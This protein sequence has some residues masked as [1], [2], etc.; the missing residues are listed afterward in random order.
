M[1]KTLSSSSL[2]LKYES[3]VW[4][5]G[6]KG[7]QNAEHHESWQNSSALQPTELNALPNCFDLEDALKINAVLHEIIF[8]D[9]PSHLYCI[10]HEMLLWF[11]CTVIP[12]LQ[13]EP[14][15]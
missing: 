13:R 12:V 10:C 3:S 11:G 7:L 4:A 14:E 2:A 8:S 9:F 5:A 1:Q 15:S 6:L